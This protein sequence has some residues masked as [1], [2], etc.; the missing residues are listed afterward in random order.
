V[1]VG[2]QATRWLDHA[3]GRIRV[4]E[5]GDGRRR[6]TVQDPQ[7]VISTS[8]WVTAYPVDLI[9]RILDVKGPGYLCDEIRREEDPKYVQLFLRYS[10]LGYVPE[11]NFDGA[12]ILDF[13]SGSGAS[14]VT[15]IRMFPTAGVV[16][17]ELLPEF[18]DIARR[19]VE[20][21]GLHNVET[22]QSPDPE[23]LP[24]GIGEFDFVNLGAV[25]EHLLPEERRRLLP[26]LWSV[27]K[28]GGVLFV[29]QLPHRYYVVEAHT[30]GL[31]LLNF[32]PDRAAHL[33]ARR[34]SERIAPDA[35][36]PD[37]LRRGIRGGTEGG[38]VDDIRSG[39]GDPDLL[40]PTRL[41]LRD[42]ADLWYAYSTT[43]RPHPVKRVMR[44]AFRAISRAARSSYAPGL[45]LALRKRS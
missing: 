25:Y 30:T 43:A 24:D 22:I 3:D 31:P 19:R 27:L 7:T 32:L 14:T 33:A 42:H 5:L 37:L 6:V 39:G 26:Q 17:V 35:T 1:E 38:I 11:A 34:F 16:G 44:T 41:G 10:L 29:N 21:Y 20:H 23:R 28:T 8:E 45:S 12:R 15:L 36:W 9:E 40:R 13:G 18:I 2:S 4:E